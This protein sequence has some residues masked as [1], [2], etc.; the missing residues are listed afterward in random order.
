MTVDARELGEGFP[1]DNLVPRG[2][3]LP[4]GH[5]MY[6]LFDIDLLR[7]AAIW[8]A[9]EE[10][11]PFTYGSISTK[12]FYE[13]LKKANGGVGEL[14]KPRGR[15][16][17]ATGL[18]PGV[19]GK[20][21]VL[22]DP[23]PANP[24]ARETGKGGW[25]NWKGVSFGQRSARLDYGP[26]DDL[27][28]GIKEQLFAHR[29]HGDMPPLVERRIQ[30]GFSA[31]SVLLCEVEGAEF[32]SV[33]EHEISWRSGGKMN[34]VVVGHPYDNQERR[35]L[36]LVADRFVFMD[37][38]PVTQPAE[39][40]NMLEGEGS[41]YYWQ[42]D[43]AQ[44]DV[45]KEMLRNFGGSN[46]FVGEGAFGRGGSHD[47]EFQAVPGGAGFLLEKFALPEVIQPGLLPETR[48]RPFRPTSIVFANFRERSTGLVSTIDGDLWFFDRYESGAYYWSRREQG[49][50]EPHCAFLRYP[51]TPNPIIHFFDRNGFYRIERMPEGSGSNR[52]RCL[53]NE[54]TQSADTRDF[55]HSAGWHERERRWYFSK[56]GQQEG[57]RHRHGGRIL[58]IAPD[59]TE[60]EE[61]ACGFRNAYIGIDPVDG[62]I[63]AVDQQGHWVPT[64]PVYQVK[65]GGYHGF[66]PARPHGVPLPEREKP[67]VYLPHRECQSAVDVVFTG[68]GD[69]GPLSNSM[70]V[71][72]YFR[73]G[74][75]QILPETGAAIPLRIPFEVPLLKGAVNPKDGMLY[76]TGFQ[77]WGSAAEE[78]AGMVRMRA[79]GEP[80]LHPTEAVAGE[81]GVVI[82]FNRQL[83]S[84]SIKP[85]KFLVQRWNYLY[86][87][88][89]GSGH[90][91][92]DGEPGQESVPVRSVHLS[93]DR[94]S[95][96]LDLPE[97]K[98]SDQLQVGF[99][100]EA[101]GGDFPMISDVVYFSPFELS[102]LEMKMLGFG[103]IDFLKLAKLEVASEKT[104]KNKEAT[105]ER[106]KELYTVAGCLACHSV[107][108]STKGKVGPTWKNLFG[109]DRE[110]VGGSVVKVD[111][112]YLVE[113]IYDPTAKI[114][115][116]LPS[117]DIGM[118]SYRGILSESDVDSLV[119][120]IE[121][122]SQ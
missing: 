6:A 12:S 29:L 99:K 118:P 17:F 110:L 28:L 50:N 4:L 13:S 65:K 75:V 40:G 104:E 1:E 5:R 72:D 122:L 106:G 11:E 35:S 18:V 86:S 114:M 85:E 101:A 98:P 73:P 3:V 91:R 24:D 64:T 66:Y 51:E 80:V 56:G 119:L 9:P 55:L 68:D 45:A 58:T 87:K 107:D 108:G 33:G 39:N 44:I 100:V 15:P 113:S 20:G 67:L 117:R 71:V 111:E 21:P 22:H 41:V 42:G 84:K 81:Q 34:L 79:T 69:L 27:G 26:P 36:R 19:Q 53:S 92:L 77:V 120:Y 31:Y 94:K 78:L 103:E 14:T 8:Q 83:K 97:M 74:L 7:L 88:N 49:I 46:L 96:F 89:Y 43:P 2:L 102:P 59:G 93:A 95:V 23:R 105:A 60:L 61:F 57:G 10:G 76:L 52:F 109:M 116:G 82:R 16:W 48:Y 25:G 90:Y 112:A 115:K 63:Y 32:E 70:L 121:A 47:A 38:P 54:F 30:S 37:L 62:K